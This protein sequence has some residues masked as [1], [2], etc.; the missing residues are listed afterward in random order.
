VT[1]PLKRDLLTERVE[2]DELSRRIGALNTLRR[3]ADGR[4]EG[5]N[6]D[7]AGFL[8]PLEQRQ[9][10]LRGR[11]TLILGAG[12]AARAAVEGLRSAGALITVAARRPDAART[13][14]AEFTVQSDGWPPAAAWDLLVNTT[15]VGM[16]PQAD[17]SPI[18]AEHL[19]P[20]LGRVVYDMVYNPAETLLLRQ[21][22]AAGARTIGGLEMLVA[23]AVLQFEWWTSELPSRAAMT[24]AARAFVEGQRPEAHGPSGELSAPGLGFGPGA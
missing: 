18:E 1:I 17:A 2:L 6:F 19:A 5:R 4:W 15:P 16:W 21:A 23:Q 8:A 10:P 3:T 22:H 14:A 9:V 11:R 7:V 24:E 12:G 20:A 13:L